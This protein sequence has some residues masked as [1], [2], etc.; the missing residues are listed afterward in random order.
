MSKIIA[1]IYFYII[2]AAAIALIVIGIFNSVSYLINS[3]QYDRYPLRYGG[4]SNCEFANDF[5]YRGPGVVA[6]KPGFPGGP[7]ETTP[8]AEE[9][10]KAKEQCLKNEEAER[11]SH[12]VDDLKNAITFTLVGL[13]LFVIHFPQARKRSE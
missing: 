2:S 8:S 13:V 1:T 9:M 7:M 4:I 5:P 3:T 11:K 10:K 6:M 12:Q